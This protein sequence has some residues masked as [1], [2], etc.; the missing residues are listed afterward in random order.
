MKALAPSVR[1]VNRAMFM[2]N[3]PSIITADEDP[4]KVRVKIQLTA[5]I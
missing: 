5:N 4:I 3:L 2:N 1:K